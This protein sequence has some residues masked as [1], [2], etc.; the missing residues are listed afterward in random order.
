M[1]RIP[2]KNEKTSRNWTLQQKSHQRDEHLDSSKS[3]CKI[4][5][6]IKT[7]KEGTPINGSKDSKIDLYEQPVTSD[8]WHKLCVSRKENGRGFASIEDCKDASIHRVGDY[9]KNNNERLIRTVRKGIGNTKPHRKTTK[10]CVLVAFNCWS[11]FLLVSIWVSFW[12][13]DSID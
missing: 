7:D 8:G 12:N 2:Q 10:T 11:I 3:P 1:R 9:I 5:W 6:S 4:L 13:W